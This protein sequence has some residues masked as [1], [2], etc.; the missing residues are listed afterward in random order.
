MNFGESKVAVKRKVKELRERPVYPVILSKK[1]FAAFSYVIVIA[2]TYS[3]QT[4]EMKMKRVAQDGLRRL[5]NEFQK[6]LCALR[7]EM[8]NMS[9]YS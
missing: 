8:V 3:P 6:D 7:G 9:P 5:V 4:A 2:V 1:G